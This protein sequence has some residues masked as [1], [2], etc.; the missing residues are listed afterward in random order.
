MLIFQVAGHV[1]LDMSL[2]NE[3][4]VALPDEAATLQDSFA[5]LDLDAESETTAQVN[6]K[7]PSLSSTHASS[8]STT[9]S[10]K[11]P[12]N[13]S[14]DENT[15]DRKK[16]MTEITE[17]PT[18]VSSHDSKD[19]EGDQDMSRSSSNSQSGTSGSG[20]SRDHST[21]A[22]SESSSHIKLPTRSSFGSHDPSPS[23]SSSSS[24]P[25]V[26]YV[27]PS[28]TTQT[29]TPF[30]PTTHGAGSSSSSVSYNAQSLM[31]NP[32]LMANT[33]PDPPPYTVVTFG[34][35][36]HSKTLDAAT[37]ASPYGAFHVPTSAFPV[38]AGQFMLGGFGFL[39]RKHGLAMDNLVEAEMV[40]SD[41][42]IVWVG[43]N[44]KHAGEW[45]DDEDPEEVWWGLR[46]A[47]PALG[48][49]TRF[50]AKAYY[51]PSVYAGNLI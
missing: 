9:A 45:K 20:S 35:G 12:F 3:I 37:A 34:A 36:V 2:L 11:R 10:V 19:S 32:T 8:D 26:T 27:N 16:F 4:S 17:E 33:N 47:G 29:A 14:F 42:R 38:G 7:R 50:R 46:G 15:P 28:P 43:E 1:I 25:R 40:L 6:S 39:G 13:S 49:V 23:A 5:R 31:G 44:G 41:G 24:A 22:T 30:F 21:P 51:V 48:V 18:R